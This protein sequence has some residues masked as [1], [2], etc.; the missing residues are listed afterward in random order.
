[1]TAWSSHKLSIS[2]NGDW[3]FATDPGDQGGK[4][5][6]FEPAFN[7]QSWKV[8]KSGESWQNQG[9][10]HYGW[11]WY[12]QKI[13]IPKEAEGIPVRLTLTSIPSDDDTWFNGTRVGGFSSEYKYK[14]LMSRVYTIPPSL[15]RYGEVNSI[16]LRIWG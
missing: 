10:E 4:E 3:K 1:D 5:K 11:G 6:W 7:D 2:I 15:V 13:F 16:A 12:R 9:V 8:L 14:N